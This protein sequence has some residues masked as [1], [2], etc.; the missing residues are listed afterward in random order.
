MARNNSIK[1]P[2][3]N[4][5][6]TVTEKECTHCHQI[7]PAS[8]FGPK[9]TRL[10]GLRNWCNKC[11]TEH[12]KKYYRNNLPL[13]RERKRLYMAKIRLDLERRRVTR[14]SQRESYKRRRTQIL[15][16]QRKNWRERFFWSRASKLGCCGMAKK[17]ASMWKKQRGLCALT[18]RSLDRS[19]QLDH[20]I[21]KANGGTD[22]MSNLRWVCSEVNYAKQ[23]L[24]D[25]EL[26][27]LCNDVIRWIGRRIQMFEEVRRESQT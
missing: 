12:Q 17:L 23:D 25:T 21:A 3:F 2:Q 19:A 9:S 14:E 6:A 24:T 22:E 1:N 26:L 20:I 4:F 8:S 27:S 18:G 13:N 10:D 5:L 7:K 11:G 16:K 15:A